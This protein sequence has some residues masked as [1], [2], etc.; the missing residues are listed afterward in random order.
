MSDTEP[1]AGDE[2]VDKADEVP[3]W[4]RG[5]CSLEQDLS[6]ESLWTVLCCGRLFCVLFGLQRRPW[7]L[8]TRC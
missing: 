2:M 8:R 1:G 5:T 3:P 7:L 6:V 4:L